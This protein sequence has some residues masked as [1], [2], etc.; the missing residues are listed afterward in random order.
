[1]N[2][3]LTFLVLSPS[4]PLSL[5]FFVLFLPPSL[6]PPFFSPSFFYLSSSVSCYE[7]WFFQNPRDN[8]SLLHAGL[9]G[10]HSHAWLGL[11]LTCQLLHQF[12]S[13]P[14]SNFERTQGFGEHRIRGT[15]AENNFLLILSWDASGNCSMI[16]TTA[17][18]SLLLAG[19]HR[20]I[21]D[22]INVT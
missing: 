8:H 17:L 18:K 5:A 20:Q 15:Y 9:V 4:P 13:F 19:K 11:I 10:V 16:S 14:N 2:L 3:F 22:K 1:M 6:L 21:K 12:L 7:P